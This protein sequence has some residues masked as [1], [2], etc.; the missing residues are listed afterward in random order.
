MLM[1]IF[2]FIIVLITVGSA[3]E[4]TTLPEGTQ[5]GDNGDI[6]GRDGQNSYMVGDDCLASIPVVLR[7]F[8]QE[9][10]DFQA[11][12][13]SDPTTGLVQED[14]GIDRKPVF[15]SSKGSSTTVQ[16][17]NRGS[18]NQWY[19]T[20]DGVNYEFHKDIILT[21]NDSGVLV[22]HNSAFFPIPADVG[23]GAEFEEFPDKNFLF[24]T[25]IHMQ[26]TYRPGQV[27]T[28]TGDDDL[29]IFIGGKLALD[30]GGL[31]PMREGTID[32]DEL[33][34]KWGLEEGKS[35]NMEIFHAERATKESNFHVETNIECFAPVVV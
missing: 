8:S 3:C 25:E 29:W 17:T 21:E 16:I 30:L 26:F 35:Y 1:R 6:N 13:G 23:Y 15:R 28:F 34:E 32:I 31:H 12:S 10:P 22:Y 24:T 2:G 14:L 19:N 33:A 5:G 9:H 4:E 27:F 11:Y 7:D 20:I 18:F